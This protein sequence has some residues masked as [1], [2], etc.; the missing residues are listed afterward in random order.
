LRVALRRWLPSTNEK[1]QYDI[2]KMKGIKWNY[3]NLSVHILS[4]YIRGTNK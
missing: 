1:I 3:L 4:L 2:N